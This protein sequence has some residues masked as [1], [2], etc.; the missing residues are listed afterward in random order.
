VVKM[1]ARLPGLR[2]PAEKFDEDVIATTLTC[3]VQTRG[4]ANIR[5][6]IDAALLILS[7]MAGPKPKETPMT[8]TIFSLE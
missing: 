1:L 7:L 8:K 3:P 6:T 5:Q 4:S 2:S